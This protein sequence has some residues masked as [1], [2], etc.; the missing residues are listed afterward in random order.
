MNT[1]G[2]TYSGKFEPK[3][4]EKYIGDATNIVWR[5]S[6][7]RKAMIY[8]DEH[9]KVISWASEEK[10]V[11][12][13]HPFKK[14]PARY[15]PDFIVKMKTKSGVRVFMVEVKPFSKCHEPKK[16]A[17][18]TRGYVAEMAEWKVNQAKWASARE[19]CET[20]GLTFIILTEKEL[21]VK[22]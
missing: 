12:Y 9:P 21:N 13:W 8:F 5:S 15:F 11:R 20:N 22:F 1:Y 16:K 2:Q 17:K 18:L 3:F 4:P 7:E 6:W 14:K 19:Y 10:F